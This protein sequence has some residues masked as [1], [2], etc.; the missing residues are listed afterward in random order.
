MIETPLFAFNDIDTLNLEKE[1]FSNQL[2]E[3]CLLFGVQLKYIDVT[4][5]EPDY[6]FG[7][8]LANTLERGVPL[9]LI[10]EN[11]EEDYYPEDGGLF[12]KFGY[13]TQ[14]DVA[15]FWGSTNYF[16]ELGITPQEDDILYYEKTKK[17]FE[18]THVT[19]IDDFKYK[20]DTRLFNYS[21]E[22]VADD[23]T[24]PSILNLED[25][26]DEEVTKIN[27][28]ITNQNDEDDFIDEGDGDGLFG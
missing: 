12:S 16:E 3:A 15:T 14:L 6:I 11:V 28:P 21:H 8:H 2:T 22:E 13:T 5:A 4:H 26:N 25:I 27:T 10:S 17:M 18:I 7:E 20:I 1:T 9:R 23:V 19:L 24:E